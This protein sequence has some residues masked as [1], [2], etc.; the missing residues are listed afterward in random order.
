[1]FLQWKRMAFFS[2]KEYNTRLSSVEKSINMSMALDFLFTRTSWTLSWDVAQSPAGS[3]PSTWGQSLS[4]S[5]KHKHMSQ[6]Q[7]M[8]TIKQKN[9]MTSYGMSLIKYQRRAYLLCKQT[10]MR[11]WGRMLMKTGKEFC[12]PFCSDDTRWREF[13]L[14][15]FTTFNN[16][17][18]ANTFGHRKVSRR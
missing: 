8:T 4:T 7:T 2:G 5:Q 13:R 14:P 1:M 18:L 15:E 9:F 16:F 12:R 6:R 17:V 11:K 10:W 3:S